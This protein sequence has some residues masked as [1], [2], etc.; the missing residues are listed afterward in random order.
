MNF[1]ITT[2]FLALLGLCFSTAANAQTDTEDIRAT[3]KVMKT[4]GQLELSAHCTNNSGQDRSLS[5]QL[6]ILRVDTRQNKSS[7]RQGGAFELGQEGERQLSVTSVNIDDDSYMLATLD[8]YEGKNLIAQARET[9][10]EAIPE[11]SNPAEKAPSTAP[12]E[13]RNAP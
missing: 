10:G 2:A 5:Y 13:G 9:I 11:Q 8:I 3:L 1:R 6:T 7:S 4:D 12:D